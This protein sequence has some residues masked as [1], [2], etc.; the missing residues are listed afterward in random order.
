M[1]F[2][3]RDRYHF[4]SKIAEISLLAAS[5]VFLITTFASTDLYQTLRVP[6]DLSRV[7]LGLASAIA[8]IFSLA[9]LVI[10]WKGGAA[11][12]QDATKYWSEVVGR[13]RDTR[14][15]SGDWPEEV[16]DELSAGYAS[17]SQRSV[18]IPDKKFNSL[19]IQYL[20]KIEVSKLAQEYPGAPGFLLWI[21][22][23]F[24]GSYAAIRQGNGE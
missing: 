20:S 7:V 8:F 13:F 15:E 4:R 17:A 19:K 10:D 16:S 2:S 6:A 5:V 9:L 18:A 21:I 23:R 3:L 11:R 14:L 24:K 12:H 22:V 1:H